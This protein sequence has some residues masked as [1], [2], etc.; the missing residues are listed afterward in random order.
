[1]RPTLS[2]TSRKAI[3]QSEGAK[4]SLS[5]GAL[6]L[7]L[8]GVDAPCD[9]LKR[10]LAFSIEHTNADTGAI[11]VSEDDAYTVVAAHDAHGAAL[12][13]SARGVLSNTVVNDV[14]VGRGTV[15]I[16]DVARDDRYAKVT[17]LV[18]PRV[19][20]VLC[21]PIMLGRKVVGALYLGT[22]GPRAQFSDEHVTD[23]TVVAAMAVPFVTQ[24]R[25]STTEPAP[26]FDGLIGESSAMMEVRRL[27]EKIGPTDLNVLV[28][29][30]TGTGK[31]LTAKA[32][33]ET[34]RRSGRTLI[35]TNC[36]ALADGLLEAELFGCKKGA[37]TGAVADREGRIEAANGSTLFLDE[38]G[39]MP[40]SMQAA[41][42]RVLQEREVV[43]LGENRPRQVDFRLV[44]ATNKDLDGEV[45]A[46][47][48]REDLLFRLREIVIPLPP[49]R[50][51]GDDTALL[52]RLFLRQCERQLGLPVHV[53]SK[54]AESALCEH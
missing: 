39:D 44:A 20:S 2:S 34:S 35:A 10:L 40:L 16:G 52:A 22:L 14:L 25:R 26:A 17:S 38:V 23:L 48:F 41:L 6:S 29:G 11:V 47:R 28:L 32:I 46:G 50:S 27:I 37:F 5:I 33:H 12:P 51:R 42:L 54:V 30:E 31:E 45:A 3:G 8:S 43:R 15:C 18:S 24:L 49:L 13:D 36:S 53:L 1:M 7:A 21:L 4:P 9:A 19:H